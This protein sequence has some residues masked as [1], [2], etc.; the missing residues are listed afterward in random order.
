MDD[1]DMFF[2]L[3]CDSLLTCRFSSAFRE[4]ICEASFMQLLICKQ[5]L[6]N[7]SCCMFLNSTSNFDVSGLGRDVHLNIFGILI[8]ILNRG[9]FGEKKPIVEEGAQCEKEERRVKES[10]QR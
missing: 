7:F 10:K 8:W 6:N 3:F 1:L 2:F 4:I 5:E 9:Q